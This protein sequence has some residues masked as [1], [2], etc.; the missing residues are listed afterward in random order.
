MILPVDTGLT[1]PKL[2]TNHSATPSSTLLDARTTHSPNTDNTGNSLSLWEVLIAAARFKNHENC[3]KASNILK[4]SGSQESNNDTSGSTSSVGPER[5]PNKRKV[6]GSIPMWSISMFC[7]AAE[8]T[9]R[10]DSRPRSSRLWW[11]LSAGA[12]VGS[13]THV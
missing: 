9:L 11:A 12:F 2:Y 10:S 8:L 3:R 5:S 4:E 6:I 7:L 13:T 1:L